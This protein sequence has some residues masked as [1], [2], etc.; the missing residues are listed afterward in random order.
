MG[1]QMMWSRGFDYPVLRFSCIFTSRSC[2]RIVFGFVVQG[3]LLDV[4]ISHDIYL[5]SLIPT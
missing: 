3:L 5:S 2:S 4:S 1:I